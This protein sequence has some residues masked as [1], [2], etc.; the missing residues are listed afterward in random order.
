MRLRVGIALRSTRDQLRL[1]GRQP[2]LA[3]SAIRRRQRFETRRGTDHAAH[4]S[5]TDAERLRDRSDGVVDGHV[6]FRNTLRHLAQHPVDN[7]TNR[8]KL[9]DHPNRGFGRKC[10]RVEV[11]RSRVRQC[12][13]GIERGANMCS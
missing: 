3:H 5:P 9:V 4:L 8:T 12:A 7:P 11:E 13:S 1:R 10:I 2:P 6:R